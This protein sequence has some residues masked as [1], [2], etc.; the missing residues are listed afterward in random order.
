[1]VIF[2]ETAELQAKGRKDLTI[3]FWRENVDGIITFNKKNLLTGM[4]SISNKQLEI[5]VDK[6]YDEF[7]EKRKKH[8][9]EQADKEDLEE[10]TQIEKEIK[11]R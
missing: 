7:N 11:K 4:G 3:K 8:D 10:L 5:L 2:L 6:A 9:L 1:V